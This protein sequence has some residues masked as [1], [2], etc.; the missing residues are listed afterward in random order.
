MSTTSSPDPSTF[1]ILALHSLY[2]TEGEAE[3]RVADS[4]GVQQV[5]GV[6]SEGRSP[7]ER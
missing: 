4:E 3:L 1:R 7:K 2:Q 6:V 5:Q